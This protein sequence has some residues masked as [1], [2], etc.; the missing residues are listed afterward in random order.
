MQSHFA[1]VTTASL[2]LGTHLWKDAERRAMFESK[3]MFGDDAIP[4]L[5]QH[6]QR[7]QGGS[8]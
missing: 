3:R 6:F 5:Q 4:I 2:S 8:G 1:I 7:N